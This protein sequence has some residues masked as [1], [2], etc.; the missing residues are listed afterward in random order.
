MIYQCDFSAAQE[1]FLKILIFLKFFLKLRTQQPMTLK[2]NKLIKFCKRII[3]IHQEHRLG[4]L[5]LLSELEAVC[6]VLP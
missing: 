5:V 1:F 2:C 3:I 4:V 6:T